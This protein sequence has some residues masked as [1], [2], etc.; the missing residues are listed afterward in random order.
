MKTPLVSIIIPF[1]NTGALA[2]KLIAST[3]NQSYKNLEII[4]V[5]DGSTDDTPKLLEK[6]QK[7]DKRVIL[8]SQENSGSAAGSRNSGLKKVTGKYIMFFDSDDEVHPKFV[9]KMLSK[10]QKTSSDLVTCGFKYHRLSDGSTVDAFT[11]KVAAR[12]PDERLESHII[13]LIGNDGHLYSVV[14]KI[15]RADLIRKHSL[16]FD[17]KLDFGEDLLFVLNYLKHVSRIEFIYEPLYYYNYGTATSTVKNS[18]LKRENWQKNWQFISSWLQ[19]QNQYETDNL[20]WIKYRWS[21]SYC[22]A[23]CRLD[24]TGSQK[25]ALLKKAPKNRELPKVGKIK[26]IGLGKYLQEKTYRRASKNTNLLFI[27]TNVVLRVKKA[28]MS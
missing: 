11:N 2:D 12:N 6:F 24:K 8:I 20:N 16:K 28:N 27:F 15:F 22:L 17:A 26:H 19:P 13:R 5:N 4:F 7:Q 23:V 3:L 18:S 1:Y 9:E 14:N 21:Y 25:R 10:I